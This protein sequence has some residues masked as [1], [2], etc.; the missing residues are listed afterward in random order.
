MGLVNVGNKP[1]VLG[2]MKMADLSPLQRH[3][4]RWLIS[5][6]RIAEQQDGALLEEGVAWRVLWIRQLQDHT[7]DKARENVWRA[8]VCR[9]LARLENRGLVTRIRGRKNARTVRV[10]FT[11]AGRK[12]ADM[13]SG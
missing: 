12:V 1:S 3:I 13:L 7:E 2:L 10:L 8:S 5:Q 11:S 4:L 9:A 6:V